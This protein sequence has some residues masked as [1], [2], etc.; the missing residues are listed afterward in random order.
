[1]L[2][3]TKT[4]KQRKISRSGSDMKTQTETL[5]SEAI[6]LVNGADHV[7]ANTMTQYDVSAKD[8]YNLAEKLERACHLLLVIGDRK[9]QEDLNRIPLPEGE[10][11]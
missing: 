3:D 5:L 11:F 4:T 8:C 1:M 10:P 2:V 7:L 6:D 9:T